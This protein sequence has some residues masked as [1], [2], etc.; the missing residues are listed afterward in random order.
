MSWGPGR[1]NS[2]RLAQSSSGPSAPR[3]GP[4]YSPSSGAEQRVV[5]GGAFNTPHTLA[6]CFTVLHTIYKVLLTHTE[7]HGLLRELV[8]VVVDRVIFLLFD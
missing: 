7:V 5:N 8:T 1:Q 6:R 2:T 4:D 3:P